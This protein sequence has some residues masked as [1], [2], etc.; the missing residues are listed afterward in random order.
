M[1]KTFH[2]AFEYLIV[3]P[4]LDTHIID[5]SEGFHRISLAELWLLQLLYDE[6]TAGSHNFIVNEA[7]KESK[8]ACSVKLRH[9]SQE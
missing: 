2:P 4:H 6:N 1:L 3:W 7:Q 5:Y 9:S 8:D